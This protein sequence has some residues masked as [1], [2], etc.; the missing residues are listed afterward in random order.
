MY[1]IADSLPG[2]EVHLGSITVSSCKP[3]LVPYQ[4]CAIDFSCKFCQHSSHTAYTKCT[5]SGLNKLVDFTH[6]C[7]QYLQTSEKAH[8]V[9][10]SLHISYVISLGRLQKKIPTNQTMAY[11]KQTSNCRYSY[12]FGYKTTHNATFTVSRS[13]RF[14]DVH[15]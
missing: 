4:H 15:S 14:P 11:Q 5:L 12:C 7:R 3:I 13:Y 6:T 1:H 8:T 9:H 2:I 10:L